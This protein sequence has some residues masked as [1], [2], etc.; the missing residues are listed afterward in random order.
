V[1]TTKTESSTN[2]SVAVEKEE[3]YLFALQVEL[4]WA[5]VG[6][7]N[8][9]VVA[10]VLEVAAIGVLLAR[11]EW[12][13]VV[14][15]GTCARVAEEVEGLLELV[16]L[17]DGEDAAATFN[18]EAL[19]LGEGV[20][21]ATLAALGVGAHL[22]GERAAGCR[23]WRGLGG[24][25]GWAGWRRGAW[26]RDGALGHGGGRGVVVDQAL[27]RAVGDADVSALTP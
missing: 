7:A 19:V 8:G 13:R 18:G 14:H 24:L 20:G 12:A 23:G 25:G 2:S 3:A 11:V 17:A 15:G 9:G 21:L 5:G 1:K 4:G 27:V 16:G 10:N 6:F 26:R 22:L